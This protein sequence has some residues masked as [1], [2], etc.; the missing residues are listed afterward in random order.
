MDCDFPQHHGGGGG[1]FSARELLAAVVLIL[2][3]ALAGLVRFGHWS[4][5]WHMRVSWQTAGVAVLCAVAPVLIAGVLRMEARERAEAEQVVQVTRWRG[6]E[7][8]RP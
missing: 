7:K 8:I 5:A 6:G 2:L 3:A 1:S 4:W